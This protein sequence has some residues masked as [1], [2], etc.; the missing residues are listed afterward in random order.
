MKQ[1]PESGNRGENRR[2]KHIH[3]LGKGRRREF[4][5]IAHLAAVCS[6]YPKINDLEIGMEQREQAEDLFIGRK[7]QDLINAIQ[8]RD[9]VSIRKWYALR[10]S[11]SSACV[12]QYCGIVQLRKG[13]GLRYLLSIGSPIF[14]TLKS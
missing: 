6:S 12:D 10:P 3:C 13:L 5:Q 11:S 2:S 7:P 9:N 14:K 8:F 4:L 1:I